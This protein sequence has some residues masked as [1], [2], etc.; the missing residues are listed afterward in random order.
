MQPSDLSF[1]LPYT[2]QVSFTSLSLSAISTA[3]CPPISRSALPTMSTGYHWHSSS[4]TERWKAMP[5]RPSASSTRLWA[6]P[7]KF[8]LWLIDA[9]RVGSLLTQIKSSGF[10]ECPKREV[11]KVCGSSSCPAGRLLVNALLRFASCCCAVKRGTV[12]CQPERRDSWAKARLLA[13][14]ELGAGQTQFSRET[15]SLRQR[16]PSDREFITCFGGLFQ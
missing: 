8:C 11:G 10:P 4:R 16:G 9:V 1:S 5:G 3:K 6:H 14:T 15:S 12:Q 13:G 2:V 7:S